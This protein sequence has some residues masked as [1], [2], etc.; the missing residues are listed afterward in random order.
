MQLLRF[1]LRFTQWEV[2]TLDQQRG[3]FS[4]SNIAVIWLVLLLS[5]WEVQSSVFNSEAD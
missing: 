2:P 4:E 5:I 3:M 1:E